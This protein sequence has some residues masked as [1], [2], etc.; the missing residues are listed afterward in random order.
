M[1]KKQIDPPKATVVIPMYNCEQFVQGVLS[2]F[3]QQSFRDFEVICVID[4]ATDGTEEE[5]KKYC[6]TDDRFRYVVR[7]NGGAGAARNTGLDKAK[8]KYIIFSDA[9]D[10][11]S[12]DYLLRLYEAAE[13]NRAEIAVCGAETYDYIAGEFRKVNK[14]FNKTFLSEGNVFSG[15]KTKR[16]LNNIDIQIA[17]KM[18]LMDFLKRNNLKFSET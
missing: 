8:G 6:K 11:Y 12:A 17:N 5:V 15:K 9:D 4:G 16:I 2:M 7:E 13:R 1:E 3:S 14:G 18:I 10:E